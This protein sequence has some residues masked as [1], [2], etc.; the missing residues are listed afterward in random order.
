MAISHDRVAQMIGEIFRTPPRAVDGG[1]DFGIDRYEPLLNLSH[2]RLTETLAHVQSYKK[3]DETAVVL[4]KSFEVLLRRDSSINTRHLLRPG[5]EALTV[6]DDQQGISYTVGL[7][8]DAYLI[9]LLLNIPEGANLRN[10]RI[11]APP[12]HMFTNRLNRLENPP[13]DILEVLGRYLQIMTLRLEA[14]SATPSDRWQR[15]ADAFFFQLGY[16]LDVAIT[17]ERY[18][19]ELIRPSRISRLRRSTISDLDAPRRYYVPDLVYHYQLGVSVESPMLEYISY[20]HVAE[21]WFE[22]VF[23]EDLVAKLQAQI[24]GPNFSYKR[25]ADMRRVIRTVTRA[26][27]LRKEELVINE[28]VALKLTLERYLDLGT[29]MS[30]LDEFESG[31]VRYYADNKVD[32][33]EGDF[34]D[35]AGPDSS[36][37]FAALARRIYKTRNA[38][39]HSKDGSKAK[40][41]PFSHDKQLIREVTLIRFIAEQIVVSS[42]TLPS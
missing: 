5:R 7:A 16:N 37:V 36:T 14:K 25:T 6:S 40:F 27:Q 30:D 32:F 24:T 31:L 33:C 26:V 4:G 17:Q 1:Y 9:F 3:I 10:L 38:L 42:S 28:E 41:V 35:L 8:S 23:E 2:E 20:Y 13:T 12:L 29:L 15:Y 19:E 39:V 22:S 34:V 11:S 18:V 21:H